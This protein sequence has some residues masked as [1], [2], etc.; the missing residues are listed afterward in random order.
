MPLD[1]ST[2]VISIHAAS[3][4]MLTGLI[5]MVQLV[6]YPL[7]A[8]VGKDAFCAYA[9]DHVR[10]ITWVVGPLMIIEGLSAVS[11]LLVMDAGW[12]RLLAATGLV[13]LLVIW[14]STI[15]LQVP[16]HHRLCRAF[17]L[18]IHRRLVATNWI[19]T[20]TWS[21]RGVLAIALFGFQ[22]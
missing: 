15:V 19:R 16:C 6:H 9:S 17:N 8:L 2:S 13:L 11:L 20:L 18:S 4:L 1:L 10:R 22:S 21:A 7:F 5:W 3:T 12:P 14:T